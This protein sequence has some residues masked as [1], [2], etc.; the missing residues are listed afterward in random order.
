LA[1]ENAE[2]FVRIEIGTALKRDIP[3]IPILPEGTHVPKAE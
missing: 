1:P 3:V 2:D